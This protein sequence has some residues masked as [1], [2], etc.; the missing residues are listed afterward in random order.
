M[1]HPTHNTPYTNY[2][3]QKLSINKQSD[4][5]VKEQLI[6]QLMIRITSGHYTVGEKLP[7]IRQLAHQLG[8]HYNTVLAVYKHLET[9]GLVDRQQGSGTRVRQLAPSADYSS[10]HQ[11]VHY[12]LDKLIQEARDQGLS[13]KDL[14]NLIDSHWKETEGQSYIYVD[15]VADILPLFKTE[16]EQH[17]RVPFQTMLLEDIETNSPIKEGAQ[18]FIS[19]YYAHILQTLLDNQ[20][21]RGHLTVISTNSGADIRDRLL[22]LPKGSLVVV[23]S[24]SSVILKQAEAVI[25]AL[26]G[27][28]LLLSLRLINELSHKEENHLLPQAKLLLCD[29]ITEERYKAISP[30]RTACIRVVNPQT[31]T[32]D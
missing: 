29:S 7:S 10:A 32:L 9:I 16:L 14:H 4:V 5:S 6:T 3:K 24:V 22:E 23:V 12:L 17:H 8:I 28:E 1:P 20:Q 26:R 18:W 2:A 15:R 27:N 13:S 11:T 21:I 19:S 31:Q 30:D 25:Q